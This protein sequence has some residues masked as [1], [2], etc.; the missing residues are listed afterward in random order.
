MD[1]F[2]PESR[3]YLIIMIVRAE[4]DCYHPMITGVGCAMASFGEFV[5]RKRLG[6]GIGLRRFAELIDEE[7]SNW[8]AVEHGRRSPPRSEDKLL[9]IADLL[10]LAE[11]RELL[12]DLARAGDE[13]PADLKRFM[14]RRLVPALLRTIDNR[15]LSDDEIRE[16]MQELQFERPEAT[17]ADAESARG[18]GDRA[19]SG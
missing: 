13:V 9:G 17:R 4:N 5:K 8:S 12:F 18:E 7:P 14:K 15:N 16:L 2:F 1:K 10:G 3:K 11:E 6:L 19:K